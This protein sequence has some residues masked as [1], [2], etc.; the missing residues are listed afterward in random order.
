GPLGMMRST[1]EQPLPERFAANAARA[2]GNEGKPIAGRWHTYPEQAAAG[3]WTTPTDL[4]K[5]LIAV[6]RPDNG[7][8]K[9][10]PASLTRE[11]LTERKGD[12]GLGWALAG[13][14]EDLAFSHNGAN[15]GFRCMAWGYA[16]KGQGAVVMTNGDNGSSLASEILRSIAAEYNWS[17]HKVQ[18]RTPLSMSKEQLAAFVGTYKASGGEITITVNGKGIHVRTPGPTAELL[19][20]S[21]TKFFPIADGVPSFTFE[22]NADGKVIGF[23]AGNMKA[24]RKD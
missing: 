19:P 5:V 22:K 15:T 23:Q 12:F 20:E 1:F 17:D 18:T 2:H 9:L 10:L 6:Q 11:M 7:E 3:L 13:K 14:D 21:L 4:A 16:K 8:M 24:T